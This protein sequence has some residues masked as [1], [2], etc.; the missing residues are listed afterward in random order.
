MTLK[1]DIYTAHNDAMVALQ[2]FNA[3]KKAVETSQKANDFAQ[4]RYDLALLST[5]ELVTSQNNLQR[6]K[7]DLLYAQYD[8]IFKIKLLEF[9]KGQGIKLR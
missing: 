5:Y 2:K 1:Q 6:A 4:K 7:I 9:Y 3:N 8:Y